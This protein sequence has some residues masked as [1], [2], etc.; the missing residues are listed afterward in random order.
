VARLN[1]NWP[2]Q[3]IAKPTADEW[4]GLDPDSGK[5]TG[6]LSDFPASEVWDAVERHRRNITP[7]RD[8]LPVGRWAP[9]LTDLLAAIDANW[10]ERAA[11]R[12]ELEARQAKA[13]HNSRGGNPPPPETTEVRQLLERSKRLPGTPDY[14]ERK[15]ARARVDVLAGQLNERLEREQAGTLT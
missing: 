1:I 7:G 15:T 14:L 5:G 9:Q 6:P 12:R 3:Q 11:A 8:G 10:R 4:F 2:G 13:A